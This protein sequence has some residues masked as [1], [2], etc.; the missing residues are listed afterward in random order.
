M[1]KTVLMP[2]AS[3]GSDP[4]ELAIPW[5]ILTA[6]GHRV[7]FATPDG[8]RG[9]ADPRMREGTNLGIWKGILRA[10]GNARRAYAELEASREFGEPLRYADIGAAST[11]DALVLPGGHDKPIRAYLES[12][13]LHAL[14]A[15][16]FAAERPVAAICHGVLVVGRAKDSSGRSLLHGRKTTSLTKSMEL[17]A[18][19]MTRLWLGDYYRTYS[20]TTED[21]VRSY[22]VQREDYLTGPVS[23]LRDCPSH[24][25]RGFVVRDGQYLSARWPGDAHRFG[26]AILDMLAIS[27]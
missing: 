11:W 6:A 9:Q 5:K 17:T 13:I 3:L 16:F 1:K 22:L 4:S 26:H 12:P 18:F 23:L 8:R 20:V 15:E 14:V 24:P 21:E 2:M 25:E 7:V 19:A 10:D 27:P